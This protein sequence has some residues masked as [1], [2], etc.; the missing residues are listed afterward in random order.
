MPARSGGGIQM[1]KVKHSS[2][3]K[4]EPRPRAINPGAVADLGIA[5]GNH[6]TDGD[7]PYRA[8]PLDAGRGYQT[9]V[10]PTAAVPGPGGGR[11]IHQRG[12]QGQ[13]GDVAGKPRPQGRDILSEFGPER[14]RS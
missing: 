13:H 9:P 4:G 7:L 3:P 6:T 11:T 10:G 1:S 8:R 12:S 5:K 2:A 14:R